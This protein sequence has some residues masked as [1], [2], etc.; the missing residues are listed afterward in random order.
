[1]RIHKNQTI[2]EAAIQTIVG[3]QLGLTEEDIQHSI[4][5]CEELEMYEEAAG[6]TIG[7]QYYKE[8]VFG[9]RVGRIMLT[10]DEEGEDYGFDY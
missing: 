1:M 6:I 5:K 10:R 4:N 3:M 7:M 8:K 2:E 9:C